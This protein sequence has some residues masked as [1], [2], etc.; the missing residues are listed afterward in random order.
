MLITDKLKKIM[1]SCLR[2]VNNPIPNNY[3]KAETEK[4]YI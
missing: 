1:Y 2:K 3:F 4:M